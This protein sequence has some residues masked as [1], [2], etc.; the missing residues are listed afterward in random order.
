[1]KSTCYICNMC[2]IT[3]IRK[4]FLGLMSLFSVK[5]LRLCIGP[6]RRT[7]IKP[8]PLLCFLRSLFWLKLCLCDS[9]GQR[10][11]AYVKE[12]ALERSSLFGLIYPVESPTYTNT[13]YREARVQNYIFNNKLCIEERWHIT[14]FRI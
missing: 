11:C 13:F 8:L 4:I 3:G 7:Y 12:L 5:C 10:S 14:T 2:H 1:M 6:L 9:S